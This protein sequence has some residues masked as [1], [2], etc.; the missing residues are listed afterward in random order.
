MYECR[1]CGKEARAIITAPVH[2]RPDQQGLLWPTGQWA[3]PTREEVSI[4]C[5]DDHEGPETGWEPQ[6]DQ[7]LNAWRLVPAEAKE[8]GETLGE[9]HEG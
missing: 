3:P 1:V 7:D 8:G 5:E 6:F 4:S 9:V 2:Y